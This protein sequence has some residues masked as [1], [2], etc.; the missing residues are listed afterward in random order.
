[1]NLTLEVG[2]ALFVAIIVLRAGLGW[3]RDTWQ[4]DVEQQFQM[5]MRIELYETLSRTE[6]YRL[7][8]L[9]TSQFIQ[10]TQVEIRQAQR[11]ANIIFRLFSQVLD[12]GAY[13]A[14]AVILSAKMT[15]FAVACG[16]LGALILV[17]LV[18]KT[19]ALSER[20]V[21]VRGAC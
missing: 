4:T 3:R 2:L 18:T 6:L 19:H 15:L 9:R 13:F 11:A 14:V 5:S 20:Q 1:L 21:G 12:L 10:S 16:V 8:Q 17:P 7:Q